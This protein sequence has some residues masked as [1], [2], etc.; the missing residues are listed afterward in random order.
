[1]VGIG[2]NG[3][4]L[5]LESESNMQSYIPWLACYT[6]ELLVKEQ[7]TM[8]PISIFVCYHKKFTLSLTV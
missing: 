8:N 7:I 5:L 2:E 3:P 1:M 6:T 4:S